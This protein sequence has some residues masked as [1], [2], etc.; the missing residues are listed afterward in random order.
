MTKTGP[1]FYTHEEGNFIFRLNLCGEV[2]SSSC[3]NNNAA[4]IQFTKEKEE[5]VAVLGSALEPPT[6]WANLQPPHD[7]YA[8]TFAPGD[9]GCTEAPFARSMTYDM[10]C[11]NTL[12]EAELLSVVENP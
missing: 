5:C 8:L 4:G 10:V 3:K 1:E 9:S 7:G 12:G 2:D 6:S 11:D